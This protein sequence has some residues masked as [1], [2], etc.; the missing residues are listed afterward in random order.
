MLYLGMMTTSGGAPLSQGPLCQ[1]DIP[2]EELQERSSQMQHA[3][4]K[5]AKCTWSKS[6]RSLPLPARVYGAWGSLGLTSQTPGSLGKL[7]HPKGRSP[8]PSILGQPT[9]HEG[10][11]TTHAQTRP[12]LRLRPSAE[13]E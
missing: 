5:T 7:C 11:G 4:S 3:H 8:A 12:R 2:Q 10:C 1:G 13:G 6:V 9:H